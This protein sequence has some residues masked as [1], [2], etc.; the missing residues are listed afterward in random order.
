MMSTTVIGIIL[1]IGLAGFTQGVTGFGFGLVAM[2][3]LP[4]LMGLKEAV[5]LTV[6]LN[7]IVCGM[8]LLSVRAHYSWRQG[9]GL[10]AGACLGVP[11][12][13]YALVRLDPALLLRVLG[14]VMVVF[15]LNE[16]VLARSASARLSPRFGFPLGVVSGGLSGA[17]NMGGPPAI[18]FCYSQAWTKEHAVAVLQVVFGLSTLM[19]LVLLGNVGFLTAPL[20]KLG[21]GSVLPLLLTIFLGRKLFARLPQANLKRA[22]FLFL[23]IMGLKHLF[24]A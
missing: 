20:L 4:L 19:R 6:L 10:V 23:G 7:L 13:V 1:V 2:P 15:A 22:V 16:L 11:L 8:M 12:G 14:G 5:A 17:F 3:L 9:L 24:F 18:A 21:L